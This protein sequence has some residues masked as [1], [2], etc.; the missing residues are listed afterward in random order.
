MSKENGI[1]MQEYQLL[2]VIGYG[3]VVHV[4]VNYFSATSTLK[5]RESPRKIPA[6]DLEGGAQG[7]G[8]FWGTW[9]CAQQHR[10]CRG[11]GE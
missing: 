2:S 6:A 4:E 9:A 7:K 3:L 11:V 5:S 8:G 10:L 1:F